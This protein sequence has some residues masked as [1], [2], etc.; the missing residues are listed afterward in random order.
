MLSFSLS[1][2]QLSQKVRSPSINFVAEDMKENI[3]VIFIYIA[4]NFQIYRI[5]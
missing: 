3:L 5:K 1:F 4:A 2:S